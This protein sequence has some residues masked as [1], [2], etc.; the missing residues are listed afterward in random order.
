MIPI[1]YNLTK[2]EV[3]DALVPYNEFIKHFKDKTIKSAI[4]R[5]YVGHKKIDSKGNDVTLY[6]NVDEKKLLQWIHN[7]IE[8]IA[9]LDAKH[10]VCFINKMER[11]YGVTKNRNDHKRM[12]LHKLFVDCGY[13]SGAFPKDALIRATGIDT[14]PYCNRE[15]VGIVSLRKIENGRLVTKNVKGQLDHFYSKGL[16]P[17]LAIS[18]NNLVPSC[19]TCNEQPNKYTEDAVVTGLINP[20]EENSFDT[21]LFRLDIPFTLY[22][23]RISDSQVNITFD[24]S[25]NRNYNRNVYTFGLL[26]LYNA[27]H[28][29]VARCVYNTFLFTNNMSYLK[30]IDLQS[31]NLP[32][33]QD[34]TY[35]DFKESCGVVDDKSKYREYILSK[36]ATDIW[37]QLET[38]I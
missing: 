34:A 15:N 27:H 16:Y 26:G 5:G 28:K 11:Y 9:N 8:T 13:E 21:L 10:M 1:C 14:C 20:Y 29:N 4:K 7:H 19:S 31:Q 23:T 32:N 35:E 37:H 30:S 33:Q 36:L 6:L 18:R 38:G 24:V 17:Y 22:G 12:V 2:Q 25:R 3:C